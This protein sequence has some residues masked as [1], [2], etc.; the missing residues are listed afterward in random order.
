MPIPTVPTLDDL[1]IPPPTAGRVAELPE[2]AARLNAVQ[3]DLTP[4]RA[5]PSR[6]PPSLRGDFL[7]S[8]RPAVTTA[9]AIT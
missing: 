1:P 4:G 5:P 6:S 9:A 3:V 8:P 7:K 2:V